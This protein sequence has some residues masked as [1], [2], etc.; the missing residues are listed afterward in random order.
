MPTVLITGASRGIGLEL[1][2]QFAADGWTVLA[3][4]RDPDGASDLRAVS[5]DVTTFS[6]DVDSAD[7]VSAL[8]NA[9][10]DRAVDVVLNNAGIIGSR[11]SFD[12]LDYDA[13]AGAMNTNV[14]GPM[15][16]SQAFA[17][18]VLASDRKQMVFISSKMA[19]IA[20]CGGGAYVYRSSK[21]A[22]NMAVKC[23]SVELG[24]KGVTAMMFHPGHVRTDMGGATAPV[25]PTES[26]AGMKGVIENL[27]TSDNGR[28]LN[29]DGTPLPW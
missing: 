4:C 9:V 18:N 1:T 23:L 28:F 27:T 16:V 19:S 17:G 2:R 24:S 26:A 7:S 12:D 10:G 15:R 20:E 29:F 5:G 3:A 6:V 11:G 13:W 22:L 25:L 8:K 14:F 21:T